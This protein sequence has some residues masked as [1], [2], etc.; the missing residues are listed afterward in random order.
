MGLSYIF[1]KMSNYRIKDPALLAAAFKALSNPHRLQLFMRL[2]KCCAPGDPAPAC[3]AKSCVGDLTQGLDIAP[4]TVSHHLKELRQ[5]GLIHMERR[6][7][8][9][10]C[11]AEPFALAA[12]ADFFANARRA[13]D[14]PKTIAC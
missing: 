13:I 8:T 1:R 6:G 2:A 11:W 9:I 7:Q 4:S 3:D 12:L 14:A 10:E 5:A